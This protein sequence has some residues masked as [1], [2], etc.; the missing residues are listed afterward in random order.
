MR[1]S[2]T[3]AD[4]GLQRGKSSPPTWRAS[5]TLVCDWCTLL[6]LCDLGDLSANELFVHYRRPGHR[7]RRSAA[8]GVRSACGRT[9]PTLRMAPAMAAGVTDALLD[10]EWIVGLIDARAPKPN[11]PGTGGRPRKSKRDAT[12]KIFGLT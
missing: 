4:I 2:R 1:A 6:A 10:M 3:T 7:M 11:K 12:S 5:S 8:S 9:A